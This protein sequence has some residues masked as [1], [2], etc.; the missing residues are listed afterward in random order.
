MAAL[1]ITGCSGGLKRFAPPG[2]VKYEDRAKGIPVTPAIAA[3]IEAQSGTGGG[4]PKLSDQPASAPAAIALQERAA[5]GD[6]LDAQRSDLLQSV[7]ADR[8]TA[9]AERLDAIEPQR[10]ALGEALREDDA[11]AR[12]ERGLPPAPPPIK[13]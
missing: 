2:F 13:E 7:E 9:A 10:D 8:A 3:R 5:L 11:A 12:A 4:F 1:A 6:A